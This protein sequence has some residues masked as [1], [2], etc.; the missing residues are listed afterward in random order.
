M[1]EQWHERTIQDIASQFK[2]DLTVGLSEADAAQR[3]EEVGPN[4]LS[5]KKKHQHSLSSFSNSVVWSPG[6]FWV[7]SLFLFTE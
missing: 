5:Q 4:L 7:R 6:C 1:A 3:L 2:I